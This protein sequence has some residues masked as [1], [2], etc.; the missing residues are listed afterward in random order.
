M[1]EDDGSDLDGE[2]GSSLRRKYEEALG[3]NKELKSR[4]AGYT[5]ADVI[6]S[7]GLAYVQ[8]EDLANVP[9]DKLEE[10]AEEIDVERR[11]VFEGVLRRQFEQAGFAGA[12][13]DKQVEQFLQGQPRVEKPKVDA[14]AFGRIRQL[15][16][17]GTAPT[18]NPDSMS[19]M[20]KLEAGLS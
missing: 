11:K 4:L 2:S 20:E 16:T 3:E 18:R 12:E 6:S 15:G 19:T 9:L 14:E 17:G 5:A 13:L 8:P 1:A 7:K 10:R